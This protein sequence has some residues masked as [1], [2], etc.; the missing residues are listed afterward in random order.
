MSASRP[1]HHTREKPIMTREELRDFSPA[2]RE[3][4]DHIT[5]RLRDVA[6]TAPMHVRILMVSTMPRAPK[7]SAPQS[8]WDAYQDRAEQHCDAF[9]GFVAALN[10]LRT[11]LERNVS[12]RVH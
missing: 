10:R 7:P 2:K 9:A 1:D 4:V 8:E 5:H 6:E 3:I 12:G 11:S